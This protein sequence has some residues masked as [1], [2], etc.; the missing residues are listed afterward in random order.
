[1]KI[2]LW[3]FEKNI[4]SLRKL[5]HGKKHIFFWQKFGSL[6]NNKENIFF[7][8]D[9]NHL[10]TIFFKVTKVFFENM[11]HWRSF[12][13]KKNVFEK[14]FWHKK[15]IWIFFFKN[16]NFESTLEKHFWKHFCYYLFFIKGFGFPPPPLF[17]TDFLFYLKTDFYFGNSF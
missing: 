14:H 3:D 13:F 5:Q 6:R 16:S 7:F 12:L 15:H 10:K 17:K 11:Y 9:N 2:L 1:M 8:F 4:F